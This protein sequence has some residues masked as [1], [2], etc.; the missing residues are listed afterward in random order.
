MT[1]L[2]FLCMQ[3]AQAMAAA[4]GKK[5]DKENLATKALGVLLENGPYGMLLYLQTQKKKEIQ[6][7]ARLYC[8]QLL[9]LLSKNGLRQYV[10]A[11]PSG[12]DFSSITDWLQNAAGDLN[13]YLFIKRLWQ[14]ALTYARYHAKASDEDAGSK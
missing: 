7:I 12:S 13:R 4:P 5:N 10:P 8:S 6:T 1:N 3:A 2:D 11:P 9:E 14:Q